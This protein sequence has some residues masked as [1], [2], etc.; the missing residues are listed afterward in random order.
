MNIYDLSPYARVAMYS[1]LPPSF[2]FHTRVIFDY[3]LILLLDGEWDMIY[4][5]KAYRCKKN[6]AIFF[7]PGIPHSITVSP[8]ASV[9]Q[10]HVHFDMIYSENSEKTPVSFKNLDAMNEYERSLIQKDIFAEYNIPCVFQPK[11]VEEFREALFGV[12]DAFQT[13]QP[14]HPLKVK[15]GL[16]QLIELLF[17]EFSIPIAYKNTLSQS[18]T[19]VKNY[20]D[21]NYRS[22]LSLDALSQQFYFNKYTLLKQF[23]KAYG[24]TVVAY[25]NERRLE[26]AKALLIENKKTVS[27]IGEFLSFTDC[28]SFSRFFKTHEGVSPLSYRKKHKNG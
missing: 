8:S 18:V 11:R 2:H 26:R 21:T 19:A 6:D 22:P 12:I 15:R 10:P 14:L 25:Y 27:E 28:Y 1:T 5:G 13:K 24:K 17:D 20:I 16:L 9:S 3:E 4:D 23:K 7:R